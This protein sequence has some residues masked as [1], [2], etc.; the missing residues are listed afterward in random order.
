MRRYIFYLDIYLESLDDNGQ[1]KRGLCC[2]RNSVRPRE[3][4]NMIIK[5]FD[6]YLDDNGQEKRG[7]SCGRNMVRP[8]ETIHVIF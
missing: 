5:Y 2:G 1:E 7:E 8:R 6:I 3:T 4:I